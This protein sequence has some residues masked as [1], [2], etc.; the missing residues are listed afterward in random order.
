MTR[1]LAALGLARLSDLDAAKDKLA[2]SLAAAKRS[3]IAAQEA[4]ASLREVKAR[5]VSLRIR[6]DRLDAEHRALKRLIADA[7]L[8][9]VV[10]D[11]EVFAFGRGEGRA[12][13]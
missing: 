11:A 7:R 1:I 10:P 9:P 5:L 12:A 6:Y 4:T 8:P 3:D 2:K 13:L